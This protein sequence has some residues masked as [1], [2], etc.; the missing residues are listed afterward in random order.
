MLKPNHYEGVSCLKKHLFSVLLSL[1]VALSM[2]FNIASAEQVSKIVKKSDEN[3]IH[4]E[5]PFTITLDNS[6]K[7]ITKQ[8]TIEETVSPL[9]T[10]AIQYN[11]VLDTTGGKLEY[12]YKITRIFGDKPANATITVAP[13]IGNTRYGSFAQYGSR[14]FYITSFSV[15]KTETTVDRIY[16]TNYWRFKI[17]GS[18]YWPGGF[19][20]EVNINSDFTLLFNKVGV[21]YPTYSDPQSGIKL[22]EPPANLQVNPR[23]GGNYRDNFITHY[24]NTYGSPTRFTWSDIQVHHMQ[25]LKYNGSDSVSNLIPLWKPGSTPKNGILSHTVLNNWWTNY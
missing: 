12:G 22:W 13:Q 9:A 24:N 7:S 18:S 21:E 14:T 8:G 11:V 2:V 5:I 1:F 16:A 4:I 23:T 3:G 20:E 10:S 17:S 19:S 6:G 15:G 25:P